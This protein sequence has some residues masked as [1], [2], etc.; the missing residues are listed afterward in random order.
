MAIAVRQSTSNFATSAGTTLSK[1]FTSNVLSGSVLL[2][3]MSNADRSSTFSLTDLGAAGN[4]FTPVT[5]TFCNA[6]IG[7]AGYGLQW[8]ICASANAGACTPQFTASV[9]TSERE[10]WLFELTG[11]NNSTTPDAS[12]QGSGTS[13]APSVSLTTVAANA[14]A[15]GIIIGFAGTI[16]QGSGYTLGPSPNGNPSEYQAFAS[17]GAHAV[18]FSQSSNANYG[19]SAISIAPPSGATTLTISASDSV[20]TSEAVGVVESNPAI[21]V[22]D[23][24]TTSETVSVVKPSGLAINVSDSVSTS[25]TV[26]AV[27]STKQINVSD[28]VT[29]A[30]SKTVSPPSTTPQVNVTDSV[31]TSEWIVVA[32]DPPITFTLEVNVSDS[33]TTAESKSATM[34]N[35]TVNASDSATTSETIGRLE[36]SFVAVSDSTSLSESV[37]VQRQANPPLT[38]SV[39]DSASI[40]ENVT[41]SMPAALKVAVSDSTSVSEARSVSFGFVPNIDLPTKFALNANATSLAIKAVPETVAIRADTVTGSINPNLVSFAVNPA[42][43]TLEINPEATSHAIDGDDT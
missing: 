11:A 35:L 17:A 31:S 23:A 10:I 6:D 37:T 9:S 15:F 13:A 38:I 7:G 39:S 28:S 25:E 41:A 42:K 33:V 3:G 8:A 24:A 19:L 2:V 12:G 30:E 36:T 1:A 43:A 14:V 4:S 29:T 32:F 34:S 27:E 5:A 18:N 20:S 40:S 22:S 16:T 26:S 21:N